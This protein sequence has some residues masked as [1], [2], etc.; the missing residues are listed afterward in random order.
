[1]I[2]FINLRKFITKNTVLFQRL[3]KIEQKQ[4]ITD[5]R[6]DKVF[7]AIE[8]KEIKPKQGIFFDGQVFDAYVFVSKLIKSAKS[9]IV[10]IDNYIDETVLLLLTKRKD[11]KV[12]KKIFSRSPC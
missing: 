3:D 10:L 1:M 4:L 6:L 11:P 5:T 2:A 8:S 12:F 9:Y 7:E